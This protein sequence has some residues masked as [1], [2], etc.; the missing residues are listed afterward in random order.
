MR[1]NKKNAMTQKMLQASSDIET[2]I[3]LTELYKMEA[4]EEGAIGGSRIP[5]G[6]KLTARTLHVKEKNAN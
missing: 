1:Q 6:T 2:E 4:N 3:Q 5:D